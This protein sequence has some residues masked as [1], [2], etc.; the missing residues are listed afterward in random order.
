[1]VA[2]QTEVAKKLEVQHNDGCRLALA[3]LGYHE[4]SQVHALM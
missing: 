1:M 2:K 4:S 3:Q